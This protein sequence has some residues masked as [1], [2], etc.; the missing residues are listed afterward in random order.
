L[1]TPPELLSSHQSDLGQVVEALLLC[2]NVSDH[3]LL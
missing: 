2:N 3:Q 1:F